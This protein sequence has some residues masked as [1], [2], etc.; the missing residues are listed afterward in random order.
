MQYIIDEKRLHK[1]F[2]KY[3]EITYGKLYFEE[4]TGE[5][6]YYDGNGE[7]QPFGYHETIGRKG[8]FNVKEGFFFYYG[9]HTI[10]TLQSMFGHKEWRGLLL[11]YLQEE[12]PTLT[13]QFVEM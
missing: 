13:F 12:F 9:K 11:K 4:E 2:K 3:M 5:I 1:V 6:Y 8:M 7:R 10:L